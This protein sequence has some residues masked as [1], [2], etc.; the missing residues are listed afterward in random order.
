MRLVPIA[1]FLLASSLAASA[2]AATPIAGRWLTEG[3]KAVVV[4]A[5]CGAQLCGRIER[6]LKAPPGATGR[7]TNNPDKALK[8][9]PIVGVAVLS[10]FADAGGDWRG[11]IYNPEDGKSYKSIVSRAA[12]GSLSVK[13]CIAFF[14]RTQRWTPAR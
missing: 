7:D 2:D 3:G 9:R 6:V 1:I 10:G 8:S 5:P 11:R 14:C 12:D 4:V 13:G